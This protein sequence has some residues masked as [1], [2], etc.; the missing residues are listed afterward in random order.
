M[1]V[2]TGQSIKDMRQKFVKETLWPRIIKPWILVPLSIVI[3]LY[4]VVALDALIRLGN[5]VF[6]SSVAGLLILWFGIMFLD[7]VL[8]KPWMEKVL[9]V[10]DIGTGFCLRTMNLYFTS[11]F[12]LLPLSPAISGGEVGKMIVVFIVGY[13]AQYVVTAYTSRLLQLGMKKVRRSEFVAT[14]DEAESETQDSL[15]V[16]E[17]DT[18]SERMAEDEEKRAS[19]SSQAPMLSELGSQ[20]SRELSVEKGEKGKVHP[21]V[22][23]D[24]VKGWEVHTWAYLFFFVFIGIPIYYAT[25]YTMPIFLSLT[26]LCFLMANAVPKKIQRVAHPVLVTALLVVLLSWVILL[27]KQR[28]LQD[29]L[30]DYKT[31]TSYIRYFRGEKGLPLPGAGDILSSMLDASIVALAMPMY[32][33][34]RELWYF[35][36]AIFI[37]N[38]ALALP[39]LFI[40]PI[41]CHAI[42]LSPARALAFAPRSVPLSLAQVSA[43]NL[44]ADM[45]AISPIVVVGGISGPIFGPTLLWL[46]R[47]PQG[48]VLGANSSA[49]AV[50]MLLDKD[51]RAAALASLSMSIYGILFV[52]LTVIPPLVAYVRGLVGLAPL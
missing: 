43:R 39:S 8:P 48:V 9:A 13:V 21:Q 11:S 16:H 31:N 45:N 19:E 27:T 22:M 44:G 49:I 52:V 41:V 42:G 10:I 37:P 50:A 33:Y 23:L 36:V 47:I 14:E 17:H 32:Q 5:T 29:G 2:T 26:V 38:L 35:F 15:P 18:V 46:L 30:R 25:G 4:Y 20:A 7:V 34:R 6:P 28:S 12:I 24:F 51:K 1:A 40:Y 3:L